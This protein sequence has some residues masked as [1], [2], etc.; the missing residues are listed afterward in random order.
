MEVLLRLLRGQAK[1]ARSVPV[2]DRLHVA[3]LGE[4]LLDFVESVDHDVLQEVAMV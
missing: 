4:V 1:I 2:E 3:M